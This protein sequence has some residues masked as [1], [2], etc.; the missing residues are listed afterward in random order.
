MGEERRALNEGCRKRNEKTGCKGG[1]EGQDMQGVKEDNQGG[2]E[3]KGSEPVPGRRTDKNK[4]GRRMKR[5]GCRS[6]LKIRRPPE[7]T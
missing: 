4:R 6:E 7:L 1:K 2:S 5:N 3:E